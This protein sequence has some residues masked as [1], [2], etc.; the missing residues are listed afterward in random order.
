MAR[1]ADLQR[2]ADVLRG[3]PH[4][5]PVGLGR[6][7]EAVVLR[8]G[9]EL[10]VAAGL[11]QRGLRLLVEDIAQALVEQQREDELLVVAGVNR[12]AQEHGRAPEVGFELL[13]GRCGWSCQQTFPLEDVDQLLLGRECRLGALAAGASSPP[14]P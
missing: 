4:L 7:L 10:R 11:R 3:L 8:V 2:R 6:N 1:M 12:A 13:L 5:A 9:G 14:P